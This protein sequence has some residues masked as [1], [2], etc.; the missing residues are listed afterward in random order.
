MASRTNDQIQDAIAR[1]QSGDPSGSSSSGAKNAPKA[2]QPPAEVS[3]VDPKLVEV[4]LAKLAKE[5]Y[6]I[7]PTFAQFF[8]CKNGGK[9]ALAY[10]ALTDDIQMRIDALDSSGRITFAD[11][12][13]FFIGRGSDFAMFHNT[14]LRHLEDEDAKLKELPA[15]MWKSAIGVNLKQNAKDPSCPLSS[16]CDPEGAVAGLFEYYVQMQAFRERRAK[17]YKECSN[18]GISEDELAVC[19]REWDCKEN[20][21]LHIVP[22]KEDSTHSAAR[23]VRLDRARDRIL[24][25]ITPK[26]DTQIRGILIWFNSDQDSSENEKAAKPQNFY[27]MIAAHATKISEAR[28]PEIHQQVSHNFSESS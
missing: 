18:Q 19:M 21:K 13:K 15:K 2:N 5:G 1:L 12:W 20:N 25:P 27:D 6:S 8:L 17:Y 3:S 16:T 28:N 10:S 24:D 23:L 11:E 26:E 7:T 9:L 22:P 4:L 14:F